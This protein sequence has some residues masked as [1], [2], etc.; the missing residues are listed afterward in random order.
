MGPTTF[1]TKGDA[2]TWL[3]DER[4]VVESGQQR[5]PAQRQEEATPK[6]KTETL[7]QYV[8]C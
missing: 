5:P 7:D 8:Q 6:T 4:R 2:E 3:P 1:S